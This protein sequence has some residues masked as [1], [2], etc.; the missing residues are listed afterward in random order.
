M[1]DA[2]S[3]PTKYQLENKT[4]YDNLLDDAMNSTVPLFDELLLRKLP[5]LIYG[6][7]MDSID[8]PITL[9]AWF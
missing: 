1:I 2:A 6:G 9:E 5:I 4:V 3:E 7:D 8:G